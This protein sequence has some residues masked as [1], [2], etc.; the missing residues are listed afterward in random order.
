L[1][2]IVQQIQTFYKYFIVKSTTWFK[3]LL[4]KKKFIWLLW[5]F[6]FQYWSC[7]YLFFTNHVRYIRSTKYCTINSWFGLRV[8]FYRHKNFYFSK[9]RVVS[10]QLFSPFSKTISGL[11]CLQQQSRE[12]R[13]KNCKPIFLFFLLFFF[14]VFVIK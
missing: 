12:T 11:P 4:K 10:W 13:A 7:F 1:A 5:V 8:Y 14:F 2:D 9:V 3:N 6:R